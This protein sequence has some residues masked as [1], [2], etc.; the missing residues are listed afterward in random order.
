MPAIIDQLIHKYVGDS[1]IV[2]YVVNV[3]EIHEDEFEYDFD[4]N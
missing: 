1:N 3:E 4:S 2:I